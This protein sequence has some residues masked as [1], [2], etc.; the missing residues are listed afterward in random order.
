MEGILPAGASNR[1][2]GKLGRGREESANPVNEHSNTSVRRGEI[3]ERLSAQPSNIGHGEMDGDSQ[4]QPKWNV[5]PTQPSLHSEAFQCNHPPVGLSMEPDQYGAELSRDARVWKVYVKETDIWDAELVDGW[6]KSLD[7]ILVFA[8][9]FSAVSS[10][11]LIESSSKLQEDPNDVSATAL[12]AISRI[13]IPVNNNTLVNSTAW[14]PSELSIGEKFNPSRSVVIVNSLWFLSLGLSLATS[15]LAMLAKDWCY[16]F[17]AH[18]IGHPWDQAQRRQRKWMMIEKWKMQ[19]LILL[20]PSLIHLSLLLFA[21]GLCIYVWDLNTTAAIP[22][23]CVSG[24]AL[25][26]YVCSSITACLVEFFPC[27]TIISRLLRS[28]FVRS[29]SNMLVAWCMMGI[30]SITGVVNWLL[31]FLLLGASTVF[32]YLVSFPRVVHDLVKG[33]RSRSQRHMIPADCVTYLNKRF[34]GSKLGGRIEGIWT[35]IRNLFSSLHTWK[36]RDGDLVTSLALGW[37]IQN[38]ETPNSVSIALQAIAGASQRIPR[39]PLESCQATLQILRRLVS[40]TG[41]IGSSSETQ[42]YVR[43]LAFLSSHSSAHAEMGTDNYRDTEDLEVLIWEF[44]L[45]HEN[46]VVELITHSNSIFLP[47]VNNLLALSMGNTATSASLLQLRGEDQR[48]DGTLDQVIRLLS[49]HLQA[50]SPLHP[51]SLQS[52]VNAAALL[53]ACA[54]VPSPRHDLAALCV[55]CCQNHCPD[56]RNSESSIQLGPGPE[57]VICALLHGQGNASLP[58]IRLNSRAQ[59]AIRALLTTQSRGDSYRLKFYWIGL[60]E[61][62]S[63]LER[64]SM[65]QTHSDYALLKKWCD[66]QSFHYEWSLFG[67]PPFRNQKDLFRHES[68]EFLTAID[69]VYDIVGAST[70]GDEATSHLPEP[71]YGVLIRIGCFAQSDVE[72]TLCEKLLSRFGFPRLTDPLMRTIAW[73]WRE[74]SRF[75]WQRYC[76]YRNTLLLVLGETYRN[77]TADPRSRHCSA[78][79]LWLFLQLTGQAPNATSDQKMLRKCLDDQA[80]LRIQALG[81]EQVKHNLEAYIIKSYEHGEHLGTYSARIVECILELRGSQGREVL[82]T[83][84]RNDLRG[85]PVYLRGL[86]LLPSQAKVH[87][88][89]SPS[90]SMDASSLLLQ[91]LAPIRAEAG[92]SHAI[93]NQFSDG[94]H[95]TPDVR[96]SPSTQKVSDVD[97]V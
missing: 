51:A 78:T 34:P 56:I 5:Q 39:E 97:P 25:I 65:S 82:M 75:H 47:T 13:L 72:R 57:L 52:L 49:N 87:I 59:H 11:F 44:K 27:T 90:P 15:F 1:Y 93:D 22:I 50:N 18:R 24:A 68:V 71:I 29:L 42:L 45:M 58:S 23:I 7:V 95:V 12:L 92:A 41:A 53:M 70:S 32:I 38:C 14:E 76:S 8:A 96:F 20:L 43:A 9:L 89:V 36:I 91:P 61:I 6:N 55:E 66:K 4:A 3:Q 83:R 94:I 77:E 81:L 33:R 67:A 10:T 73:L 2:K 31:Y 37:L 28:G 48:P 86:S 85:V 60:V 46:R 35:P 80:G 84:V 19:E 30:S 69:Q 54:P 17:A 79:Q 16:S 63:H 40:S 26:F 64:Y 88:G 62:L 21:I 74:H